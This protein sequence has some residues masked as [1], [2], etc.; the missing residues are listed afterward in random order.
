MFSHPASC[1]VK[2]SDLPVTIEVFKTNLASAEGAVLLRALHRH[3]P[4]LRAT[5]DLD[6]CDRVLRVQSLLPER[7]LWQ[8]V[9]EFVRCLNVEI[10]VLPD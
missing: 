1:L 10:S 4:T 5:L 2:T 3:F 6:D 8:Q 7:Q 9:A